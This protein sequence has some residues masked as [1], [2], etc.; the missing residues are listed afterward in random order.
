M[1]DLESMARHILYTKQFLN[2][3]FGIPYENI[4]QDFHPDTFGHSASVPEIMAAGG[5]RYF[6][7]CRGLDGEQLYR[8][9]S[10]SG[11]EVLAL[12]EPMWYND[13]IRAM[14]LSLV[15]QFCNKYGIHDMM[16]IYGVG[17]HGGRTDS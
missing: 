15:P 4:N 12:N 3:R 7:H 6:Y 2:E 11:A 10:P 14:Y 13:A 16:K 5:I 8:W 17:D 9:R 1:P